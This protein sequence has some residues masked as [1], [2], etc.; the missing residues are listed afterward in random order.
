MTRQQQLTRVLAT[1]DTDRT[2]AYEHFRIKMHIIPLAKLYNDPD[3]HIYGYDRYLQFYRLSKGGDVW[4]PV[5]AIRCHGTTLKDISVLRKHNRMVEL[6]ELH[7]FD[8][9]GPNGTVL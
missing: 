3:L 1:P 7:D 9:N 6:C 8:W 4:T 5:E 2:V